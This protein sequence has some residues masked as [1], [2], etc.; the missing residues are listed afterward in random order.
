MPNIERH[1][2][3]REVYNKTS[4]TNTTFSFPIGVES[5]YSKLTPKTTA[6]FSGTIADNV[7]NSTS[8]PDP[9][10]EDNVQA[11]LERKGY[12][13]NYLKSTAEQT[14]RNLQQTNTNVSKLTTATSNYVTINMVDGTPSSAEDGNKILT[15]DSNI[16]IE[17][18][19]V[20]LLQNTR[21]A[22]QTGTKVDQISQI[23]TLHEAI[24][25][26]VQA[27]YTQPN[28]T[29]TAYNG[30][31]ST[32]Y[33]ENNNATS[34]LILGKDGIYNISSKFNALYN[35]VMSTNSMSDSELIDRYYTKRQPYI[36]YNSKIR[37]SLGWPSTVTGNKVKW[38]G[39]RMRYR[40]YTGDFEVGKPSS[41]LSPA[42][43]TFSHGGY[44]NYIAKSYTV[45]S[46]STLYDKDSLPTPPAGFRWKC[47]YVR[48]TY[49][50]PGMIDKSLEPL[51]SLSS[52][53]N[54][55]WMMLDGYTTQ[56]GYLTKGWELSFNLDIENLYKGTSID[57]LDHFCLPG[58]LW[59]VIHL[60]TSD[61]YAGN[62]TTS[63][64]KNFQ[65]KHTFLNSQPFKMVLW[66]NNS[67]KRKYLYHRPVYYQRKYKIT[68][69]NNL[70][71]T[72]IGNRF[73]PV[74]A[75]RF[76]M[77][78]AHDTADWTYYSY[79]ENFDDNSW[80]GDGPAALSVSNLPV[81]MYCK[82][83][84]MYAEYRLVPVTEQINPY[85]WYDLYM[86]GSYNPDDP[87]SGGSGGGEDPNS[88]S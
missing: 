53:Q 65:T 21:E 60:C 57:N 49:P 43:S 72:P 77:A 14:D 19:K 2:V 68:D 38:D 75:I 62:F 82:D 47:V 69:R 84:F 78:A 6:S 61:Y 80:Q 31:S 9:I 5:C 35:T 52:G 87:D 25:Y 64:W 50:Y 88:G 54:V 51:I 20:N 55:L 83:P 39:G 44:N 24:P 70:M 29:I 58:D 48:G 86:Q 30:P 22:I 27:N 46:S 85:E 56:N 17:D 37:S 32:T 16:Q 74:N 18:D 23:P 45:N 33:D 13:I 1:P 34:P 76:S 15:Q 12:Q 59:Q 81:A 63:S 4:G 40:V 8:S 11:E 7:T 71:M 41:T 28:S 42:S 10:Y 3:I 79:F 66:G 67:S 26:M 73:S 36:I